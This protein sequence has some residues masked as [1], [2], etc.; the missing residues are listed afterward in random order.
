[1][2]TEA[3]GQPRLWRGISWPFAVVVCVLGLLLLWAVIAGT[4]RVLAAIASVGFAYVGQRVVRDSV[5]WVMVTP[6]GLVVSNWPIRSFVVWS[7]V[8]SIER[9]RS[10]SVMIRRRHG[11]NLNLRALG[12]NK[13]YDL[14]WRDQTIDEIQERAGTS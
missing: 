3:V 11:R 8:V 1:M 6:E 13:R 7:D 14:T 4:D 12:G 10:G 9:R 2:R 5:S